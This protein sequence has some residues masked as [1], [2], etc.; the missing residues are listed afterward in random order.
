[1]RLPKIIIDMRNLLKHIM[2]ASILSIFLLI[3]VVPVYAT[4]YYVDSI[5]GDDYS[6]GTTLFTP[7]KSLRKVNRTHF[8]PGDSILL[9]RGAIWRETLAPSSS[10]GFNYPIIFGAYGIGDNPVI[11]A[12][13][14]IGKIQEDWTLAA[15]NVWSREL[16]EKTKIVIFNSSIVGVQSK[17]L[18]SP[19][20][21][22]WEEKRLFVYAEQNPAFYYS[23]IEAG[24]R[25]NVITTNNQKFI[26][27][28]DIYIYGGQLELDHVGSGG[29]IYIPANSAHIEIKNNIITKCHGGGIRVLGARNVTLDNNTISD[30]DSY[31]STL[32]GDAITISWHF[33]TKK[34]PQNISIINNSLGGFIDRM[35]IAV[36]D[37]NGL[38]ISNNNITAGITGIDIEPNE[39]TVQGVKNAII[40]N[41]TIN[42]SVY[43]RFPVNNGISISGANSY[44]VKVNNNTINSNDTNKSIGMLI[45][46]GINNVIASGNIIESARIGI[47]IGSRARNVQLDSNAITAGQRNHL[48]G[49][50]LK[51]GST[52]LL[53]HNTIKGYDNSLLID[54]PKTSVKAYDNSFFNYAKSGIRINDVSCRVISLR[55]IFS[56][57]LL[58][59]YHFIKPYSVDAIFDEN[60]YY[61]SGHYYRW[62]GMTYDFRN[63]RI[64]SGQD[65]KGKEVSKSPFNTKSKWN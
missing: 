22:W 33:D 24:Q 63:Y 19:Y 5:Y 56:S 17:S 9:K 25:Y 14:N 41:N 2:I 16:T 7:W 13:N 46:G 61:P 26:T 10:G 59:D 29:C 48:Y 58:S 50:F 8:L 32:S 30:I 6:I 36:L 1:M 52:T 18:S 31:R 38:L 11:T 15:N 49:I 51:D 12:T 44:Y 57:S 40:S 21:F 64:I 23:N 35:G 55:N 65:S 28:Q 34:T 47:Q 62:N 37:C 45:Y 60:T 42:K 4:T 27:I 53:Q 20:Q 54:S 43:P 3:C 39:G